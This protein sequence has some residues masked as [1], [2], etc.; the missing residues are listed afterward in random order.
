MQAVVNRVRV[1]LAAGAA[2]RATIRAAWASLPRTRTMI[3]VAQRLQLLRRLAGLCAVMVLAVTSLS[4]YLRL[5]KAGFGCADWPQCYGQSL[6]QLQQGVA[7]SAEVQTAT[8]AAR[9]AHRVVAVIAL[10]LVLLMVAVCFS[11]GPVLRAEGAMAL[12]LLVLA[13]ALAVL[14]RWSSMA[15]VPAVTLGNLL[16]GFAMLALCARLAVAGLALDEPVRPLKLRGWVLV[17]LC[18]LVA[19]LALGGLVSASF[20]GLSCGTWADCMQAARTIG[21]DTGWDTLNPWREP[22]LAALPPVNPDGAL[23]HALHRGLA[24]AVVLVLL[25]LAVV[26]WRQ[27]RRRSAAALMVILVAQVAVGSAMVLGSLPLVLAL[28][29][30]LLGAGL[31]TALVLLL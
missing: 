6:R 28:L 12:A 21:W 5:D 20:A 1:V 8:A 29:H 23:A 2:A 15:R 7:V 3:S 18:M 16:G 27:G 24:V 9:L 31:L 19:Q 17:A 26:A 11:G 4:A 22:V 30:N 10:L 25:P 13:L 14:G